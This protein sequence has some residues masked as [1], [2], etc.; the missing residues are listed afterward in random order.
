MSESSPDA[1]GLGEGWIGVSGPPGHPSVLSLVSGLRLGI[2]NL[3]ES[4]KC[5][6]QHEFSS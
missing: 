3:I 1:G 6:L 5:E 2:L 4:N